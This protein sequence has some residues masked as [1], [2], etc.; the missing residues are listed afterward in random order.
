MMKKM[1]IVTSFSRYN[2]AG[3]VLKAEFIVSSM[4]GNI[5]FATPDPTLAEV[6]N[7]AEALDTAI[8]EAQDGIKAKILARENKRG[9]LIDLLKKLSLYVRL[10]AQ[11]N[12]EALASSGFTLT[13]IPESIGIL[14]K[15]QDFKIEPEN[16]GGIKLS[17]KTI[18]GANSYQYEYRKNDTEAW[19]ILVDTKSKVLITGLESGGHYEFRVTGIGTATQ[20]VYSDVIGSFIL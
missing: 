1:N 12:D 11:D 13:K 18:K 7:A 6:K 10:T 14:A 16:I 3:L 20:R 5:Y 17:L 9:L 8:V 15:P 2:N 19:T 4:T